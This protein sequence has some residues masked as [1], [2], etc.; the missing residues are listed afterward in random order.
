MN[1]FQA[2]REKKVLHRD[3]KLANLFINDETLVIG[4][5]GFAKSGNDMAQTKLGTPLTMAYEILTAT[6]DSFLYNSKADLWSVGVVYYQM[7]FGKTPFFG[8]TIPSLIKDINKKIGK[9]DFPLPV[10]SE[11]K[12]LINRLLQPDPEK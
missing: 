3:F 8:F 12:D 11:S 7:L 1:G 10:S 6:S 5:F 4:D 9:L 2:L